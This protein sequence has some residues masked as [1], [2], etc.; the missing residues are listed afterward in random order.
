MKLST[1]DKNLIRAACHNLGS[2]STEL[3][4]FDALRKVL[5]DIQDICEEYEKNL[6]ELEL[7]KGEYRSRIIGM[8]K[9]NMA[10]QPDESDAELVTRLSGDLAGVKAGELVKLYSK[11]AARFRANFPASFKYLTYPRRN[12]SRN[13]WLDHKI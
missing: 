8:L 2:E 4:D 12:H 13:D 6:S 1:T 7:I 5:T 3:V 11:V 9:A 10:C